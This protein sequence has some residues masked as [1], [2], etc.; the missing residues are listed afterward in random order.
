MAQII[1]KSEVFHVKVMLVNLN[2]YLF[3]RNPIAG[4]KGAAALRSAVDSAVR[5]LQGA[6]IIDTKYAGHARE[7]AAS[8]VREGYDVVV[9]VGGDGTVNE[10]SSA[11]VGTETALG[12]VPLGSG[13][14]LARHLGIPLRPEEAVRTV[15]ESPAVLI[16][17]AT[18]ND[19]PFFCTAGVG[20]DAQVAADY[21]AAGTRGLVTY[22]REALRDWFSYEPG[23]YV[24]ET[25]GGELRTRALLVT[26]GNANQW[27]N[28][29][30]ITPQASLQDGMLDVAVVRRASVLSSLRMVRQL[31]QMNLFENPDVVYLRSPFVKIS[32]EGGAAG[33]VPSGGEAAGVDSGTVARAADDVSSR[34]AAHFDGEAFWVDGRIHFECVPNSLRVIPGGAFSR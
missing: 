17:T 10:V 11:L 23:E 34:V 33:V 8:A 19:R 32:C 24:I 22:A 28:D 9:A 20:F 4:G 26:V 14:G 15:A 31:R 27:G 25:E 16:D 29:Y 21:A 18:V 13:N 12:I 30:F 6:E 5:R 3:V 1:A 2:R 7:L